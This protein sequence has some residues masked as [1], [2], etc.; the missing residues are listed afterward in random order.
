[1]Q[2][3]ELGAL[4]AGP[5]RRWS[6]PLSSPG[7]GLCPSS[8]L[9]LVQSLPLTRLLAWFPCSGFFLLPVPAQLPRTAAQE[10]FLGR[11]W[12][13]PARKP[14]ALPHR[15][16]SPR[17][18]PPICSPFHGWLGLSSPLGSRVLAD[19]RTSCVGHLCLAH[20]DPLTRV[21]N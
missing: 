16:C 7:P 17:P 18:P 12:R 21:L 14:C 2:F 19:M 4:C 5:G 15:C 11:Y 13:V 20:G 6:S 10:R 1:M 3:G 9:G 8:L